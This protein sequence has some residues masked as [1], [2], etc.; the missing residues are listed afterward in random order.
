VE[1]FLKERGLEL[2]QEKTCV[3]HMEEGFDFL[4]RNVRKYNGK[5][6]IKPA[7]KNVQAFLG[8][9]RTIIRENKSAKA[10]TLI[11]LL[12]PVIRGWAQF[13][14]HFVSKETFTLVD[15]KTLQALWK[16]AKRRHS[17][18]SKQWIKNKYFGATV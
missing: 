6:L 12:N 11:R 13:H 5:L 10:G 16:W 1:E 9:V 4:G 7:K 8:K 3:T 2:S 15:H 17:N 18:K 14:Q